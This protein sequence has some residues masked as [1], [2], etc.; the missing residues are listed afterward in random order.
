MKTLHLVLKRQWWDMIESLEKPEEYRDFTSHWF[1]RLVD[2]R[3]P[4]TADL[5][6]R[7]FGH[8]GRTPDIENF[9]E[10]LDGEWILF[11]RFDAVCFHRGYTSTTMSFEFKGT[12]LGK[13]NP[14]WGAPD[15]A[16]FIIRLGKLISKSA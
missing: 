6:T 13:G 4:K 3:I 16:L 8:D 15:K 5:A 11:K 10:D 2:C 14:A 9:E 12:S 7:Y 1:S